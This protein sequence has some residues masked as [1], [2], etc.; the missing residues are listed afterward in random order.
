MKP[1][2]LLPILALLSAVTP[3][4]DK[5]SY[6]SVLFEDGRF[7]P[8]AWTPRLSA[9]EVD[10]LQATS[11]E[12]DADHRADLLQILADSEGAQRLAVCYAVG[13][14][15]SV[16]Y[17][18]N[19]RFR[20]HN[21]MAVMPE[22]G[23]HGV[24]QIVTVGT[25]GLTVHTWRPASGST[26]SQFYNQDI[27]ST[28]DEVEHVEVSWQA[29]L[30]H[31]RGITDDGFWHAADF[32]SDTQQWTFFSPVRGYPLGAKDL[33]TADWSTSEDFAL[34]TDT[35]VDV[36]RSSGGHLESYTVPMKAEAITAFGQNGVRDALAVICNQDETSELICLRPG[37]VQELPVALGLNRPTGIAA[38]DFDEDGLDDVVINSRWAPIVG[39]LW[40]AG[41][42]QSFD[43][44]VYWYMD[45][46]T[47]DNKAIAG[48]KAQPTVLD[49]D[50]DGDLDAYMGLGAQGRGF[51]Q[52]N[53]F[54]SEASMKVTYSGLT[55]AVTPW[56]HAP[57]EF[58]VHIPTTN[59][60]P[61]NPTHLEIHLYNEVDQYCHHVRQVAVPLNGQTTI[62]CELVPTVI[63]NTDPLA[64]V[65]R[66]VQRD[67]NGVTQAAGP[68]A[69]HGLWFGDPTSIP[70]P[71]APPVITGTHQAAGDPVGTTPV[72][73]NPGGPGRN[74]QIPPA[75]TG[76]PFN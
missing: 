70:D 20:E 41:A 75:P 14:F 13:V 56:I 50:G 16:A 54:D 38:G 46:P 61:G 35:Q 68:D 39:V 66:V 51:L 62:R 33:V 72:P 60:F 25:G 59:P 52:R 8:I 5:D 6:D 67:A 58:D 73:Y 44:T 76:S 15:N 32:N 55:R 63:A 2:A 1:P 21:D 23:P 53:P 9:T 26:P 36:Y 22:S 43:N 74:A 64:I 69:V 12:L 17:V 34:L 71:W 19:R 31:V 40:N 29:P 45:I 65:M 48:L 4:A 57:M 37:G 3:A 7:L 24:D 49:C 28:W 11:A 27:D 30:Y 10:C 47:E 18:D 42:P